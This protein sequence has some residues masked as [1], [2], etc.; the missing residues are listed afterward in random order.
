MNHGARIS[1]WLMLLLA[2]AALVGSCSSDAAPIFADGF[3]AHAGEGGTPPDPCAGN[4]N[5]AGWMRVHKT[6]TQTFSAPDGSP[7]VS[8]PRGLSYPGPVGSQIGQAVTVPF[9]PFANQSVNL[10]WDQVQARPQDG[11]YKSRPADAMFF[12]ITPCK[13]RVN[14]TDFPAVDL[15]PP[16]PMSPNYYLTPVCRVFGNSA[17]LVWTSGF[18]GGCHVDPMQQY[19]LVIAPIY[20]AT[21]QHSCDRMATSSQFGCDVGVRLSRGL[22][23]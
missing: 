3:E 9:T 23:L 19:G 18:I 17:A 1:F 13:V 16:V 4:L 2:V 14:G 7:S 21:G 11:Y 22:G 15:R 6:W 12:A 10:Y 5:P 8:Y 20:P